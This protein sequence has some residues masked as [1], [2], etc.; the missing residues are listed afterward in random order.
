MKNIIIGLLVLGFTFYANA[1]NN[2]E[3]ENLV[4]DILSKVKSYDNISIE[5]AYTL[6][7]LNEN[8]KQETRGDVSI[9]GDKYLLNLMGTTRVFD[10]KK[11]YTIIPED[12]EVIISNYNDQDE[13]EITPSKMLTFFEEGYTYEMDIV[14]NYKG[15]KIQFIKLIPN[16]GSNEDIDEILLGVDQQTLHLHTLIQVQENGTKTLIQVKSFKKNQPL[17]VKHFEFNEEQ[18]KDYYINRLD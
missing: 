8:I 10:G 6:E 5:F 16:P 15:R 13:N 1:Q 11:I 7:N 4:Q 18:Y 17:S 3:A 14:Q 12:E 9:E 2:K